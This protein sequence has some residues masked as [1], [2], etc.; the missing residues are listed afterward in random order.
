MLIG[1]VGFIGSGKGTVGD[2]LIEKHGFAQ[3]SFA[4]ALKD[5]AA[6]IFDWDREML[7]GATKEARFKR[8]QRDRFW[9]EKLGIPDFTPRYALQILGTEAGRGIFGDKIWITGLE[10]RWLNAGK[11]DTVVTDCRFPNEIDLIRDLNGCV[12]RVSRGPEP[13]WYQDVLF[14]NKGM[15]DEDDERM[16]KQMKSTGSLP[17]ESETAWIGCD[18]DENISND[19]EK[20]DLEAKVEEL[21]DRLKDDV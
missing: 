19:D 1:V 2:F 9:S 17:H 15:C 6:V 21:L 16:I 10:K 8:E 5:A 14:Y 3:E 18:F 7:E 4:K 20:E 11:P 12:V 13:S